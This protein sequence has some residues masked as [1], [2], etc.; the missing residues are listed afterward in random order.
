MAKSKK[1]A[2]KRA[3]VKSPK[4][5]R[6]APTGGAGKPAPRRIPS[7]AKRVREV[8]AAVDT[9]G[10]E[11]VKAGAILLG[12]TR[13]LTPTRAGFRAL[14]SFLLEL[15]RRSRRDERELYRFEL[16]FRYRGPDGKMVSV[17]TRGRA[18][19]PTLDMVKQH[20]KPG[21]SIPQAWRRMLEHDI[22]RAIFREIDSVEHLGGAG[23]SEAIR[24]DMEKKSKKQVAAAL[25]KF[26]KDRSFTFS[27]TMY[28]VFS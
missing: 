2:K 4:T 1:A 28:R 3:R 7:L 12:S 16:D 26:K 24:R 27:V 19:V 22:R 25:R 10:P 17:E 11:N 14:D 13:R 21:E 6:R 23:R 20:K 8:G 15:Q 18:I 9:V 5:A